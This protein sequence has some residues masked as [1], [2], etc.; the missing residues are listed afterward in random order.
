MIWESDLQ[1]IRIPTRMQGNVGV[2]KLELTTRS[3]FYHLFPCFPKHPARISLAKH[4]W[5]KTMKWR[6]GWKAVRELAGETV[7]NT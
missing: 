7:A 6:Q 4:F 3:V 5:W 1:F 2:S